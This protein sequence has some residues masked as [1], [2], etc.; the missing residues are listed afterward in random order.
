MRI[1]A[2]PEALTA[3]WLT[4]AL[5]HT[6]TLEDARV[7]TFETTVLTG[8]KGAIGRIA[9]LSLTYAPNDAGAPPSSI[10][11]KFSSADPERRALYHS[12]GLYHREVNFYRQ[13]APEIELTVPRCYHSDLNTATGEHVL[14]LEDFAPARNASRADGCSPAE[15]ELAVR[16]IAE[17]HAGHWQNPRLEQLDWVWQLSA[18]D[19]QSL[20][21]MYRANWQPF[22][23][24]LGPDLPAG[25]IELGERYASGG[26]GHVVT[27]HHQSPQTLVH[28][29]Y[30]LD[31]FFY[32][33]TDPDFFGVIDWQFL[34][35]G[36][37]VLDVGAFLGGNLPVEERR[38]HEM[39]LLKAYHAILLGYGVTGYSFEACLQ[40]YRFAMLDG[41]ARMVISIGSGNLRD[42]Q[43]RTHRE[44]IWP[45]YRAALLDLEV[46][47]LLPG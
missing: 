34:L 33:D 40:D 18:A 43:E 2:G 29:D 30:Q 46:A 4:Q 13:L 5:N 22:V 1:P 35:R 38:A 7:D 31:N 47:D 9:R 8:E 45:R 10:I 37:G 28:Y 16:K 3:E 6:R 41:L 24:R 20:Q 27:W 11:A 39:R 21:D 17:F 32:S 19:A 25:I 14:L 15:A 26:F 23:D 12:F 36:R 42:E 44:D